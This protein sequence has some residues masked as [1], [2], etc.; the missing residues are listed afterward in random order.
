MHTRNS[1]CS[2]DK[3][4]NAAPTHKG[5]ASLKCSNQSHSSL[6][7]AH[8]L[9]NLD[10]LSNSR[11]QCII[12]SQDSFFQNYQEF[13][14]QRS[15]ECGM[16]LST[17]TLG[18]HRLHIQEACTTPPFQKVLSIHMPTMLLWTP[19]QEQPGHSLGV[20]TEGASHLLFHVKRTK[21]KVTK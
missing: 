5:N 6:F 20:L 1:Q 9:F 2:Y 10:L 15:T 4:A 11:N 21:H 7:P 13:Q 12:T 8:L 19:L 14:V 18:Q 16:P 3:M 17:E